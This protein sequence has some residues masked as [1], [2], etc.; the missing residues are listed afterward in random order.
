MHTR[1]AQAQ[2]R[3]SAARYARVALYQGQTPTAATRAER[4]AAWAHA[5]AL[6]ATRTP[7]RYLWGTPCTTAPI[8]LLRER[9]IPRRLKTTAL[10][11]SLGCEDAWIPDLPR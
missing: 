10:C 5:A 3:R 6:R 7:S 8:D 2:A 11:P 9:Q 1:S 4:R